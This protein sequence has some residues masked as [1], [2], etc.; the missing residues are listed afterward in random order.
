MEPDLGSWQSPDISRSHLYRGTIAW[1]PPTTI[2]RAYTVPRLFHGSNCFTIS[3]CCTHTDL[4]SQGYF[5]VYRRSCYCFLVREGSLTILGRELGPSGV[6][7]SQRSRW[8]LKACL[9]ATR[10]CLTY[11]F[12]T[13]QPYGIPSWNL[14]TCIVVAWTISIFRHTVVS[15]IV[16]AVLPQ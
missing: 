1:T 16:L 15:V 11:A 14:D 7:P 13:Q 12:V 6:S 9:L 8:N 5:G 3:T 10:T 4:G 2:Y